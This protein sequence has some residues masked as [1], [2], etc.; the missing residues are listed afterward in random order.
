[1]NEG[2]PFHAIY[3]DFKA[4]FDKFDH[5]L[6]LTEISKTGIHRRTVEWCADYLANR[7]FRVRVSDCLSAPWMAPSGVPQGSFLSPLL[8]SINVLDLQRFIPSSVRYLSLA[9]DLKIY[10]PA[11]NESDHLALQSAVDGIVTWC[12][13][14]QMSLSPSECAVSATNGMDPLS[15]R[16]HAGG[17]SLPFVGSVRDLGVTVSGDL[18]FSSIVNCIFRCFVVK[19][20]GFYMRLII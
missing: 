14:N 1:M 18:D 17:E 7:S 19:T 8:F 20:P 16:Y 11:R 2:T 3:F 10:G 12:T 9:D 4:A 15:P 5:E 13:L 6:L